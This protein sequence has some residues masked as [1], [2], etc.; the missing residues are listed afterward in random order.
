[1]ELIYHLII[2][3]N[4]YIILALSL[5]LIVGYSGMLNFS[6]IAFYTVGAYSYA[7]LSL[8]LGLGFLPAALVGFLIAMLLSL[9]LSLPAWK[10]KGD[11]FVMI[12]L[13]V[14]VLI[15][16]MIN[17]WQSPGSPLGTFRN[18]TNGPHG[19]LNIP[20]IAIFGIQFESKGSV[21][22]LSTILAGIFCLVIWL[23]ISSPWGRLLKI[24]RD[25]E[26]AARGLGKNVRLAKIQVVAIGSG[27]AAVS[28]ALFAGYSYSIDP[29]ICNVN[30]S[31]LILCM[32][33]VGGIGNFKGPVVGAVVLIAIPEILQKFDIPIVMASQV[34]LLIYGLLLILIIHFRPQGIAGKYRLE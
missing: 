13:A 21:A 23:L 29:T 24:V 32:V 31:L 34:R 4:I 3:L 17:N 25:D 12:S 26:L 20:D 2:Y 1:M 8:K 10:L 9:G 14:Q 5:N 7:I 33:L 28:G 16:S 11:Y 18:L 22:L 15:F 19:I 30:E 6:H 27:F